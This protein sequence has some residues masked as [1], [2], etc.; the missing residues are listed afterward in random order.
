MV[1]T[2]RTFSLVYFLGW[3]IGCIAS[4]FQ[5]VVDCM[6]ECIDS[7]SNSQL[8]GTNGITYANLCELKKTGCTGTQIALKHFGVCP[9]S[10]EADGSDCAIAMCSNNVEPVCDLYPSKLTTYQNSCHFR[11][12]R[13]QA[14]HGEK[15][16]LLNGPGEENGKLR[17]REKDAKGKKC[18]EVDGQKEENKKPWMQ[19]CTDCSDL[20]NPKGCTS[21]TD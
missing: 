12:A 13:C 7:D 4:K 11:A 9:R 10:L 16:E 17:K 19:M 14:L 21:V 1:N 15:G 2:S 5:S 3:S 18:K 6:N 20:K 8:C